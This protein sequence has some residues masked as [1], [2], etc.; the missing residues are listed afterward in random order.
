MKHILLSA[1]GQRLSGMVLKV[2]LDPSG[3]LK[4]SE[5]ISLVFALHRIF[6][7]YLN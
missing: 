1:L 4:A 2:F 6:R 3:V 5:I 7:D